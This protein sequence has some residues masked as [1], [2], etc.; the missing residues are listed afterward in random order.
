MPPSLRSE[1]DACEISCWDRMRGGGARD[2]LIRTEGYARTPSM[3]SLLAK[4]WDGMHGR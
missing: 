1:G 2:Q 4:T 3:H